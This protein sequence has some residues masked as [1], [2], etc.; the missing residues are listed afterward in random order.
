MTPKTGYVNFAYVKANNNLVAMTSL[1][2]LRLQHFH[3]VAHAL[4]IRCS[5]PLG[6]STVSREGISETAFP[7]NSRLGATTPLFVAT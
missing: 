2:I 6:I 7:L 4:R 5:S 1:Q 3:R